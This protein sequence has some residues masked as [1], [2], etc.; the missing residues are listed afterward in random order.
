MKFF[1]LVVTIAST[2]T[3]IGQFS[4]DTVISKRVLDS[5]KYILFQQKETINR[6]HWKYEIKV[7]VKKVDTLRIRRDSVVVNHLGRNGKI[8]KQ[9]VFSYDK[10]GCTQYAEESFFNNKEQVA[11]AE[12]WKFTC[13]QTLKNDDE[14]SFAGMRV[15]YERR[16]YDERGRISKRILPFHSI[17]KP[18]FIQ[19]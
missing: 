15:H 6:M 9:E 12:R 8:I 7:N 5:L 2:P 14:K 17:Y 16:Q 10:N 1:S 13:D 3:C 4:S 11:Y 19:I 18:E